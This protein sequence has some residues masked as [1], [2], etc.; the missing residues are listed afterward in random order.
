[1]RWRGRK[2]ERGEHGLRVRGRRSESS[3]RTRTVHVF[4]P[5]VRIEAGNVEHPS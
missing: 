4:E 3:Q 5:L 1:L 2:A